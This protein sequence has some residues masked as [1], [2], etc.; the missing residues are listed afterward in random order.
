VTLL[1]LLAVVVVFVSPLAALPGTA[2]RAQQAAMLFFL[3]IALAAH[4]VLLSFLRT[5]VHGFAIG[6]SASLAPLSS[7]L[8]SKSVLLC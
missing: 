1:L 3:S 7:P 2:L 4:R 6:A 5:P 8:R